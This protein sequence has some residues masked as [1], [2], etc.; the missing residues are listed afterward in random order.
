MRVTLV[1]ALMLLEHIERVT[2]RCESCGTEAER[3][4]ERDPAKPPSEKS[5][6]RT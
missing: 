6:V 2:Y 5:P 3:I 4:R 1:A